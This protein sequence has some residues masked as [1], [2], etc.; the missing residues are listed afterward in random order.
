MKVGVRNSRSTINRLRRE[1]VLKGQKVEMETFN[2]ELEMLVVRLFQILKLHIVKFV[3]V[4][5]ALFAL[6][7]FHCSTF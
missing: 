1:N 7:M 2:W 6:H 5:V 3:F 4:V